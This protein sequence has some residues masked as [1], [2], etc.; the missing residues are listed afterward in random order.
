MLVQPLLV[1][2]SGSETKCLCV[3][4][5]LFLTLRRD[6][7]CDN[8]QDGCTYESDVKHLNIVSVEKEVSERQGN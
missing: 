1:S 4:G 7:V 6:I 5:Q 3:P 8:W 2:V